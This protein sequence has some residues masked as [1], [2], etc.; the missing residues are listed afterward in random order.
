[1]KLDMWS[2]R[3]FKPDA[4]KCGKMVELLKFYTPVVAAGAMDNGREVR[5]LIDRDVRDRAF[6]VTAGTVF[7]LNYRRINRALRR[8]PDGW[9]R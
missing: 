2:F 8:M 7:M 6:M 3:L 1:M 4:E 9:T 5:A